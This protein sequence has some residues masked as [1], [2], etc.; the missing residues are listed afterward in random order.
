MS[1]DEEDQYGVGPSAPKK[2]RRVNACDMC[3]KRKIKC[4]GRPPG[5]GKQSCQNC[6]DHGWNCTFIRTPTKKYAPGY[7]EA[8]ETKI[9]KLQSLISRML[10]GQDFTQ[11][12][13]FELTTENWMLPGVCGAPEPEHPSAFVAGPVSP[14]SLTPDAVASST[15]SVMS[16]DHAT[17]TT[18]MED[19]H[20]SSDDDRRDLTIKLQS[21]NSP[22]HWVSR[23]YDISSYL[24]KSSPTGLVKTAFE[25]RKI[26]AP[27][28]T[29]STILRSG[30]WKRP[31]WLNDYGNDASYKPLHFPDPDLM[32]ELVGRYFANINILMP[33]LH[34]PT[35]ED[36][37]RSS[38][39]LRDRTFGSV[40]LLVC[41]L[42][43][44]FSYD[45][46]VL[47][48]GDKTWLSAGW[49]WFTQTR[50]M[51][52]ATLYSTSSS[53]L[54]ILQ[55]A[56]LAT[57]YIS[58]VSQIH[59][60]M[61]TG[62]GIRYALDIGAH[63]RRAYGAKPTLEDEMYKRAF[64]VLIYLDRTMSTAMGR[65]CGIQEEDFDL[66][67]P[68]CCDDEYLT[69]ED[70][71]QVAKQPS[72]KPSVLGYFIWMLKLT[73]I[74]GLALRTLYASTKAKAHY[75]FGGEEWLTRTVAHFDSLLNS[76]IDNV[77]DQLRWDPTRADDTFFSQSAHLYLQ[78][79]TTQIMVHRPFISTSHR[80]PIPFPS[81]AICTNA[82]R[83]LTRITDVLH[84][85]H[86]DQ[87][88]VLTWV[89]GNA[90]VV[91]LVAIAQSRL[92]N[93]KLDR[94]QALADVDLL[95]TILREREERWRWAGRQADV[96]ESL[97]V[98]GEAPDEQ[99]TV[100]RKR[101]HGADTPTIP[102]KQV[103]TTS[104]P[105]AAPPPQA[106]TQE[107]NASTMDWD[108]PS[109]FDHSASESLTDGMG[110]QHHGQLPPSTGTVFGNVDFGALFG[111]GDP[112]QEGAQPAWSPSA[113][114]DGGL[115]TPL[116]GPLSGSSEG[117][118]FGSEA[119]SGMGF[120][121]G[122]EDWQWMVP[123]QQGTSNQGSS[124]EP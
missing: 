52:D 48:G 37:L 108:A 28:M 92:G 99:P 107:H 4:D 105:L 11:E 25:L 33:V 87:V 17:P 94:K 82:A 55:A 26:L 30:V 34:R 89:T 120:D 74:Q 5:N 59:A 75:N 27:G 62:S 45:R 23:S 3:R 103:D 70:P 111:L 117:L 8:L 16:A 93:F 1:S 2:R 100:S 86:R 24:G 29:T 42:G 49:N 102:E 84:K 110:H 47:V 53:H 22:S 32:D 54:H 113:Y 6:T 58:G 39:H 116:T 91:T 13:G 77:P 95:I 88:G 57:I 106:T 14:A 44:R 19:D 51:D 12:V 69:H 79:H 67:M 18:P 60:W 66:E 71:E 80:T 36:D 109:I 7:V 63:K 68:H 121:F 40:V 119:W 73:Q 101:L 78:Y 21:L 65:P 15:L 20:H 81:L 112:S 64:W 56:C 10:P 76:W 118:G 90:G 43:S 98:L 122:I 35:F 72:D 96:L 85:R 115:N 41:A 31:A 46:R 124:G 97:R 114:D 61:Y 83:S 104:D 38:L 50:V 123:P 9:K